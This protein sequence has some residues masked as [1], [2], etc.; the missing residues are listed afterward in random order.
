MLFGPISL[1]PSNPNDLEEVHSAGVELKSRFKVHWP[2]YGDKANFRFG[3]AVD[4]TAEWHPRSVMQGFEFAESA[5][6]EKDVV[7]QE[8]SQSPNR[9]ISL[10]PSF[11]NKF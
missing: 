8:L 2:R 1:R 3:F 9:P 6:S 5:M 7:G 10:Q 4:R 11:K